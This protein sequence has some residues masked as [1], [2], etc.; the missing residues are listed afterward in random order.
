MPFLVARSLTENRLD[1]PAAS[2]PASRTI[3][4]LPSVVWR[5]AGNVS[6]ICTFCAAPVPVFVTMNSTGIVSWTEMVRL[7]EA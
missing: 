4:L 5:P 2:M 1:S 6:M 7:M 3:L